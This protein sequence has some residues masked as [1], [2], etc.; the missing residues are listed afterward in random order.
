[1]RLGSVAESEGFGQISTEGIKAF[2]RLS[3][4]KHPAVVR[5]IEALPDHL[6]MTS[7]N[8]DK[9]IIYWELVSAASEEE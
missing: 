4:K 7:A 8:I 3:V 5:E 6:P 2:V 9:I 1:M